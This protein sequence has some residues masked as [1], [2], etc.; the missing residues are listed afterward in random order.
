MRP[1]TAN[2]S[3]LA[4]PDDDK[5]WLVPRQA[6]KQPV[7]D[8]FVGGA[9]DETIGGAVLQYAQ[10][11]AQQHRDNVVYFPWDVNPTAL[12]RYIDSLPPDARIN[13]IGHSYGG[14]TAANAVA[15]T[16][17]GVDLLIMIDPVS[18]IRPDM[19]AVEARAGQWID[20][21]A[22]PE[23][24]ES[25]P[26]GYAKLGRKWRTL[27]QGTADVFFSASV[28]HEQFTRMMSTA[29]PNGISPQQALE[30]QEAR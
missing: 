17:K 21:D 3:C 2:R 23:G 13:V 14:D 1:P 20:V 29:G 10:N 24:K 12:A 26:D 22:E 11:E 9:G 19:T 5:Q 6:G 15:A 27:P 18:V 30:G 28:H 7:Y 16:A 25:K 4:V 8:I